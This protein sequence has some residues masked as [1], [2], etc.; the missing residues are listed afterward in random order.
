MTITITQCPDPH[1]DLLEQFKQYASV[2][3]N[4][5]DA[6]LTKTLKRAMLSVQEYSD[7]AMLPCRIMLTVLDVKPGE[8]IK[9]YQGGQSVLSV[10][11]EDGH[12]VEYVQEGGAI[13]IRDFHKALMVVYDNKV[14]LP[15]AEPLLPVV[16]QLATAIYDG[17]DAKVQASILRTS[18]SI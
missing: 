7:V 10:T 18:Y 11:D 4:T 6:M 15:A 14:V 12:D 16:W 2:P 3:D 1:V 17:E 5:R 13:V 9:L 8:R